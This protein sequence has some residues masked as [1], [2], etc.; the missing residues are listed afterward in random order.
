MIAFPQR[1]DQRPH[2]GGWRHL[3][4]KSLPV[5]GSVN[6]SK[7]ADSARRPTALSAV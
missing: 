5:T 7:V 3:D 1:R 4:L 2:I 6:P